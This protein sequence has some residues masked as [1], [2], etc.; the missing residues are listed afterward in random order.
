[1]AQSA[2]IL[3]LPFLFL[4]RG[5]P[6]TDANGLVIGLSLGLV[7]VPCA[8]PVL[9]TV[10]ALAATGEVGVRAVLVTG[11][12]ALGAALPILAIASGGARLTAGLRPLRTHAA[13]TRRVAGILIGATALAIALGADTRF[14]TAI[15]G[16]IPAVQEQAEGSGLCVRE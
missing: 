15:P 3:E 11:A 1:C 8:G 7:F 14:T 2:W 6:R 10:A 9:A 16:H 12:Y 13:A 5:A 4:P